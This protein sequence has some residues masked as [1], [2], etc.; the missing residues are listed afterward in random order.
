MA[1]KT[2]APCP[3]CKNRITRRSMATAGTWV[4]LVETFN[5]LVRTFEEETGRKWDD[6]D[7]DNGM[8]DNLHSEIPTTQVIWSE[9]RDIEFF[10]KF[11]G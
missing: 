10:R 9:T 1:Q 5:A 3:I 11:K 7:D 6:P 2:D 4:G 8:T